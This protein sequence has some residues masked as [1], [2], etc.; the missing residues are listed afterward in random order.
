MEKILVL[1][2]HTVTST[3]NSGMAKLLTITSFPNRASAIKLEERLSTDIMFSELEV[4]KTIQT[5]RWQT[6][7][8]IILKAGGTLGITR[9]DKRCEEIGSNGSGVLLLRI[10]DANFSWRGLSYFRRFYTRGKTHNIWLFWAWVL[11]IS[12]G[13]KYVIVEIPNTVILKWAL[14]ILLLLCIKKYFYATALKE[15]NVFRVSVSVW[16]NAWV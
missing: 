14:S 8:S 3:A 15:S 5:I 10:D 7:K 6:V 4:S 11:Q 1:V 13:I 12:F 2:C 9:M 16:V